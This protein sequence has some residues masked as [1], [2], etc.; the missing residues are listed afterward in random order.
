MARRQLASEQPSF[1]ANYIDVGLSISSACGLY[2]GKRSL[3]CPGPRR[4]PATFRLK[5]RATPPACLAGSDSDRSS[6]FSGSR[7][8]WSRDDHTDTPPTPPPPQP[9]SSDGE[10]PFAASRAHFAGPA[11]NSGRPSRPYRPRTSGE[12][13]RAQ[14]PTPMTLA[15][16]FKSLLRLGARVVNQILLP[17]FYVLSLAWH[18]FKVRA[19]A[20]PIPAGESKFFLPEP[21][22]P[23]VRVGSADGSDPS[24]WGRREGWD[25]LRD[26]EDVPLSKEEM[27]AKLFQDAAVG[28]AGA[29]TESA[30][31]ALGALNGLFGLE[32]PGDED[33]AR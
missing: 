23:E 20:P 2:R 29:V 12:E 11:E 13:V 32:S 8:A 30:K 10:D 27:Q 22:G 3:A 9:A 21:V 26:G 6:P 17:A 15:R 31:T 16:A 33:R 7:E 18:D 1:A 4:T 14:P 5:R 28:V 19:T 25:E 24:E